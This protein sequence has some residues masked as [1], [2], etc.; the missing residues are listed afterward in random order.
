MPVR[1]VGR[2]PSPV[3]T[4]VH[5]R[6]STNF[7][8]AHKVKFGGKMT[9]QA[10][11]KKLFSVYCRFRPLNERERNEENGAALT[12]VRASC[13]STEAVVRQHNERGDL[14]FE[15]DGIH[16]EDCSQ[17]DFYRSI[18]GHVEYFVAH[19]EDLNILTYGQTSSGKTWTV[20]GSFNKDARGGSGAEQHG[21]MPRI[22]RRMY[23]A[24]AHDSI[25][26]SYYEIYCDKVYDLFRDEQRET[27][28]LEG[29]GQIKNRPNE[30]RVHLGDGSSAQIAL[31]K[32]EATLRG[33]GDEQ[34]LITLAHFP[35]DTRGEKNPAYNR[36]GRL[37]TRVQ[38]E[39][40]QPNTGRRN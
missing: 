30:E 21:I 40:H 20:D 14:S 12:L 8:D 38:N 18:S 1:W 37:G 32:R 15:F 26:I 4:P 2:S 13:T 25:H 34:V 10:D 22:I 28:F 16:Y 19:D 17:N 11:T 31:A 39:R 36:F 35:R 33:N 23:D 5:P 7:D 9:D 24:H 6:L 3:I 29:N 27:K